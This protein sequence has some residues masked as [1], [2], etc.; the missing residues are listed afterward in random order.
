MKMHSWTFFV[1]FSLCFSAHLQTGLAGEG[2]LSPM[3]VRFSLVVVP[4]SKCFSLR[5][6]FLVFEKFA[7]KTWLVA[8][9]EET[10]ANG[11]NH[12]VRTAWQ[13]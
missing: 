5:F 11:T 13:S 2:K 1:V 8:L 12:K 6:S 10:G 9:V 3:H 7:S 4:N